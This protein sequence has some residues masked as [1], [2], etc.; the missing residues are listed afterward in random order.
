M[1]KDDNKA[2]RKERL[3]TVIAGVRKHY[4]GGSLVLLGQTLTPAQLALRIQQ[5][6]DATEAADLAYPA[7]LQRVQLQRD[8][9]EKLA[10]ILRAL[11]A[12]VFAKFG[13]AKDAAGTLGDFGLSPRKV[14]HRPVATK[15]DAAMKG[16]ATRSARKTM[17]KRQ[18]KRA[19][20]KGV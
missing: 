2:T 8:S 12:Q 13:D 17:G 10:P 9:H 5:D 4:P 3:R 1:P 16:R 6:I 19:T 11:R 18:R 20:D 15:A 14:A 7:W